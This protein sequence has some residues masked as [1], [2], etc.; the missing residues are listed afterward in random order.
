MKKLLFISCF[1][2]FLSN[3]QYDST[4]HL[5]NEI[6]ANIAHGLAY[7]ITGKQVRESNFGLIYKHHFTQNVRIRILPSIGV[8]EQRG[9][10]LFGGG[11]I[12]NLIYEIPNESQLYYTYTRHF[13]NRYQLKTGAEYIIYSKKAFSFLTGIDLFYSYRRILEYNSYEYYSFDVNSSRYIH[14]ERVLDEHDINHIQNIGL[15]PFIGFEHNISKK[16]VLS[17]YFNLN[18]TYRLGKT[19]NFKNTTGTGFE[20]VKIGESNFGLYDFWGTGFIS[21]IS[22]SYKF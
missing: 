19:E 4:A 22:I 20:L 3:S 7:V 1:L 8:F 11:N 5:R 15:S 12:S 10:S 6:G 2:P 14:N 9:T 13:D 17:A 16:W 21:D 18:F